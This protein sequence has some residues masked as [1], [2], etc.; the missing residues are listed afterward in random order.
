M[1]WFDEQIRQRK[2]NDE[3][4]FADS[5]I[6][7]A[8]AVMGRK[9]MAALSDERQLTK[10]AI[11]EILKYYHIRTQDVPDNMKDADEQLEFLMRPHGIMHRTVNLSDGWYKDAIGAMLGVKKSDK[12]VV[13]FIPNGISGYSYYDIET[14]SRIR[15]TKQNQELF[16]DEALV[17]YKPFP[18]KKMNVA[19]LIRYM[20]ETLSIMDYVVIAAAAF[21]VALLGMLTPKL[22]NLLFSRV[23]ESG[24]IQMLLAIAVFMV[25]VTI[26]SS[27]MNTLK[28]LL[29]VKVGIKMSI[30]VQG[31]SANIRSMHKVT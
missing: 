11:D 13:A 12:S 28:G 18:L 9:V 6:H 10:N 26:S 25:C 2:K 24:S 5:F 14:G 3:D 8:G 4:V 21:V 22:N 27:I 20:V 7:I 17:F 16:E 31:S 23:V 30:T 19:N 15:I 1:G 29:T